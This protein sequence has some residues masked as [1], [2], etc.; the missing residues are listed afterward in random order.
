VIAKQAADLHC[1]TID[2]AAA[3][4]YLAEADLDAHLR[5]VRAAYRDRRDALHDGLASA[6]PHGSTWNRPDGG[7][8]LWVRLPDGHDATALLRKAITH[9]VAY[10]PGAPFFAGPADPAALRMSFTTHTPTEIAEGLRR[11]AKAL[12]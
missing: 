10:V 4:Q 1:S 5:R 7:M 9:D 8:F 6:L 12:T 3:A 11:L 2:Q